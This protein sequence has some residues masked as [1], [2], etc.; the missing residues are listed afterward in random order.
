MATLAEIKAWNPGVLSEIAGTMRQREQVLIHSG[1]DFGRILP[2]E[3]WTGP[4]ADTAVSGHQ[5]FKSRL[6]KLASGAGVVIKA[7]TQASDAIPA[8]Q[9]VITNLEE[10]ARRYGFQ[11]T[12]AGAVVDTLAGQPLPPDMNPDDR[13]RAH[14]QVTTGIAAAMATADDIDSDLASVL[15]RAAQGEFG[16]GNEATVA[17][18]AAAGVADPG[19]TLLPPPANAT[20]AQNAAWW[21]AMSPIGRDL[22]L[23]ANPATVGQMDGLPTVDRDRANRIVLDQQRGDLQQRRNEIQA[24]MDEMEE[25]PAQLDYDLL[26][27]E[28]DTLDGKIS[29]LDQI[30]Q[31]LEQ[32]PPAFL[33]GV[34]SANS[35]R[36]IVAIGNP[37][38]AANVATYVP[39][40]TSGLNSDTH[41]D[42]RRSDAMAQQAALAGAPSTA[43]ITWAGYD[44]P[45]NLGQA[46]DTSYADRAEPAL[47]RFQ[48]GLGVA[49]QPG[50]VN[51]TIIGHSYG[52]T[53]VGQTARDLGLPADQLVMVASPGVGVQHAGELRL[54]GIPA[55]QAGQ[56]VYSTKAETDPIPAMTNFND[57]F[58][59]PVDPL[60]P[61]PTTD[62]FG[63]KTFESTPTNPLT[64]HSDYWEP[65]SSSLI[66]MGRIIAGGGR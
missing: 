16:T 26:K 7:L 52:T 63:G 57:R 64:S 44:A 34:D 41:I 15:N 32:Q 6:N 42:I 49:H 29:G 20:P 2:V 46:A 54:D 39:G 58:A 14:Q 22:F 33:L 18:A 56:H 50:P 31:R 8:V 19:L 60:G 4:A 30:K 11:L 55:D 17:A 3:G 1:D 61:D 13:A 48:E 28:R 36:A 5:A 66:E 40:T 23:R 24:R 25:G 12:D 27:A 38:T 10:L 59:D 43:V 62:W 51:N 37:D 47:R 9:H 45:Q 65:R 53:V 35:G 21:A